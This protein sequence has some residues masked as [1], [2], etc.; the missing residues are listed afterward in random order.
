MNPKKLLFTYLWSPEDLQGNAGVSHPAT[1]GLAA[2]SVPA[3]VWVLLCWK[4]KLLLVR[5]LAE[6][7]S[8][9]LPCVPRRGGSGAGLGHH[10]K[11]ILLRGI[12]VL[13]TGS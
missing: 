5:K 6:R 1:T 4:R 7:V 11:V 3:D 2:L 12:G 8:V 9:G 10:P 13:G